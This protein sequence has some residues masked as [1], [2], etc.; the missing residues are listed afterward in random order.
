[1]PTLETVIVMRSCDQQRAASPVRVSVWGDPGRGGV[2]RLVRAEGRAEVRRTLLDRRSR[3][4]RG[5]VVGAVAGREFAAAM[6]GRSTMVD[7]SGLGA[8]RLKRG[9][10]GT[11]PW[12]PCNRGGARGRALGGASRAPKLGKAEGCRG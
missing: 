10:H 5:W 1:M 9:R 3:R 8:E 4:L 7:V 6:D 2:L 12:Q 11:G